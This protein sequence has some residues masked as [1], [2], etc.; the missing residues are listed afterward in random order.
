MLHIPQFKMPLSATPDQVK[1]RF[2]KT[3]QIPES[4]LLTFTILRESL[5]A[6]KGRFQWVYAIDFVLKNE[7]G[8]CKKYRDFTLLPVVKESVFRP[9]RVNP[10]QKPIIVGMGPAGLF[11]AYF[12]ALHGQPSLLLER[13]EAVDD[14]SKT[15]KKL[16]SQGLLHTDSNVQFGEGGAGTF[17][18]GKLTT[19]IKD[20]RSKTVLEILHHFGAPSEILY[21]QKPHIGT[22]VLKTVI[23]NLRSWLLEN[24]VEIH[25]NTCVEDI[26]DDR[27]IIIGVQAKSGR[28]F[29]GKT[30]ILATGH[31]ARDTYAKLYEKGVSMQA[32][33]FAMGLRIEHMQTLINSAQYG[34]FTDHPRLG[35][36]EY[37]LTA[38]SQ[39]GR[40][41]Y[42]FCMCPGGYVVNASSETGR[43]AVNGMSYHAR[44]GVNA[45]SALLVSV[46]PDDFEGDHPLRGMYGQM[47]IEEKAFKLGGGNYNAPVQ[48]LDDFISGVPTLALGRVKPSIKPGY[49]LTDLNTLYPFHLTSALKEG[50]V[51][52]GKKLNG[53]T[54]D[55]AILTGV[56]TRTSAP[57][58]LTRHPETLE[59][60]SHRG[61]YPVG[62]GAGYAG[63]IM[64]S[65]VDGLKLA[66]ILIK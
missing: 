6:R 50:L 54:S 13:G 17:S 40:G 24:G 59:S 25:Y 30:V 66:E 22:D 38:Q 46:N 41:V 12:L 2:L 5:D 34:E 14:R 23:V 51:Q 1:A 35:A 36:A 58:R 60:I 55:D 53:F 42:T 33:P 63:G 65:A 39:S 11:C 4:D 57:V 16:W 3:Y 20:P 62:E 44:T 19:R 28:I 10:N 52:M 29:K 31:S 7:A 15:V 47:A 64:S 45:N 49:T 21:K 56:E 43:L 18:D 48:R 26:L 27:G 61:L 8:Y 32:K 9:T 37:Q